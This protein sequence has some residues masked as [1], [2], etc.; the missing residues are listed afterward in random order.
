[1][2]EVYTFSIIAICVDIDQFKVLYKLICD[3]D[4]TMTVPREIYNITTL[5]E[6]SISNWNIRKNIIQLRNLQFISNTTNNTN[7]EPNKGY[8]LILDIL[9][10]MNISVIAYGY[11]DT[12]PL[13]NNTHPRF[14][15]YSFFDD[16]SVGCFYG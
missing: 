12:V 7:S 3:T 16:K 10:Q 15:G 2:T 9:L 5:A 11:F 14:A 8:K 4:L 13:N 1:M 6:I